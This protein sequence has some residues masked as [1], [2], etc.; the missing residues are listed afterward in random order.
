[1]IKKRRWLW[2]FLFLAV[3]LLLSILATGWN[4]VLVHDYQS[5]LRLAKISLSKEIDGRSYGLVFKMVLGTLGFIAAFT[6][7]VLL[8]LKLLREMRLNQLQA[9]FLATVSHELK[10]PI[11]SIELTSGLL[12]SGGISSQEVDTLWTS[13]Q[14]ELKRLREEVETLLEAARWQSKPLVSKKEP[15]VLEHWLNQSISRWKTMLGPQAII[16]REGEPLNVTVQ[17][18][19]QALNLV[20]NNLMSNAKKF[21][22]G[23]P[24]VVIRTQRVTQ[25]Q[26]L[27][28]KSK[29]L[30]EV[31][32]SGWGF[33]PADSKRIFQK[34]FRS[35]NP[36]PY[37]ISGTG[38][39]LYLAGTACHALGLK[40]SGRSRGI[41]QGA[42][43]TL[44]GIE[45][46]L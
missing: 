2:F 29:W 19:A 20:V 18:D 40:L 36:A 8:F 9:E 34:F 43:F 26:S 5:I 46:Q 41:G 3:T 39:G 4:V 32:D 45:P 1:M 24:Q 17:M 27:F 11:A 7:T 23:S 35:K 10:T 15:I 6:L 37:A 44:E 31:E 12:R 42:I 30:I 25:K 14:T 28:P 13:H 21:S 33:L 22:N 38:L 16:E